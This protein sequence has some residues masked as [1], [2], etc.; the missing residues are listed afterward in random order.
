VVYNAAYIPT[1][2]GDPK[3]AEL[4]LRVNALAPLAILSLLATRPRPFLYLSGAQGYQPEGRL[5]TESDRF[6]PSGHATYYLASKFLGDIYTEHYRGAHNLPTTTLRI[7]SVY[8]PGQQRGMITHFVEQARSG[9]RICLKNGGLHQAD[10]TFVPD[11]GAAVVA[12]LQSKAVGI[13]NIGAG[14]ATTALDAAR[15]V[16][17]SAGQSDN[18][19]EIEPVTAPASTYGFA[20]LDIAKAKVEIGYVP[21]PPSVGIQRTVLEWPR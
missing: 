14:C 21:T 4:C 9:K 6:F 5:A 18:L 8:G 3:E 12:V 20:A 7:G 13:F 15:L 11:V 17:S 19:L 2:Y 10:L 1:N 16:L